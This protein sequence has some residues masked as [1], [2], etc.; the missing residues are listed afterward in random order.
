MSL[1]AERDDGID[2]GA[3]PRRDDAGQG[4]HAKDEECDDDERHRV[5]GAHTEQQR[6]HPSGRQKHDS[7]ARRNSDAADD[8]R[9]AN[10]QAG[11][12]VG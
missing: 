4:R 9:A 8:E 6:R 3:K 2:A 5:R 10:D 1:G 7:E 12:A 11:Y